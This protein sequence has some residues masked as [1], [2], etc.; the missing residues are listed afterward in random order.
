[1]ASRKQ[2]AK[3]EQTLLKP[4]QFIAISLFEKGGNLAISYVGTNEER[5]EIHNEGPNADE[6]VKYRHEIRRFYDGLKAKRFIEEYLELDKTQALFYRWGFSVLE[7]NPV[8]LDADD[9]ED[10]GRPKKVE[11]GW[12]IAKVGVKGVV[13]AWRLDAFGGDIWTHRKRPH[14]I[15]TWATKEEAQAWIDDLEAIGAYTKDW[16]I[17][18]PPPLPKQRNATK[19]K[20]PLGPMLPTKGSHGPGAGKFAKP[21]TKGFQKLDGK[22]VFDANVPSKRSTP[23]KHK[24]TS[25]ASDPLHLPPP[26]DDHADGQ[27]D[28]A[29]GEPGLDLRRGDGPEVHRADVAQGPGVG[30]AVAPPD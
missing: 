1:M 14:R 17:L 9:I 29:N 28:A 7:E 2:K 19:E 18:P 24:E 20:V 5:L 15:R 12:A 22:M 11:Q 21:N 13:M 6:A 4:G 30:G 16:K 23:R 26:D 3:E 10:R 8:A 27:H 25:I